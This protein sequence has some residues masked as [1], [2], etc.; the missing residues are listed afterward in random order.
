M[1][2]SLEPNHTISLTFHQAIVYHSFKLKSYNLVLKLTLLTAN[3]MLATI[4]TIEKRSVHSVWSLCGLKL[5]LTLNQNVLGDAEMNA[6]CVLNKCR[7][8]YHNR[9][10][11]RWFYFDRVRASMKPLGQSKRTDNMHTFAPQS[12]FAFKTIYTLC[13]SYAVENEHTEKK[14]HSRN[15]I[16]VRKMQINEQFFFMSCCCWCGAQSGKWV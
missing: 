16:I 15:K 2:K 6:I 12:G 1:S 5:M 9:Y 8:P 3:I 7:L 14:N 4:F 11:N 13:S 10:F